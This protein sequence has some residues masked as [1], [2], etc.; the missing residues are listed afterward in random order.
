MTLSLPQRLVALVPV[1]TVVALLAQAVDDPGYAITLLGA[2]L[3]FAAIGPRADFD[4]PTQRIVL[5]M[6]GVAGAAVGLFIPPPLEGPALRGPWCALATAFAAMLAFRRVYA[7]PEGLG[8][9]DLALGVSALLAARQ[10][11]IAPW[12]FAATWVYLGAGFVQ[13]AVEDPGRARFTELPGR[14]RAFTVG[15]IGLAVL[16]SAGLALALPRFALWLSQRA[17]ASYLDDTANAGFEDRFDLGS[18]SI[19]GDSPT[20]AMRL[21][22][23]APSYLR[24]AVWNLYARGRWVRRRAIQPHRITPVHASPPDTAEV[25]WVERGAVSNESFFAPLNA[26]N[27][28]TTEGNARVD[29]FGVFRTIPGDPGRSWWFIEGPRPHAHVVAPVADD[30]TLTRR[31]PA[32]D[33]YLRAL[34]HTWTADHP[35]PTVRVARIAD[36][37]RREYRYA[38]TF[39]RTPQ[40]DPVFDFL[41]THREGHCEYFASA[42]TLLSRAADVPARVVGG[43]RVAEENTLSHE[44]IVRERNAHAW[45]EVYLEG[46]WRTLDATP[47][48]AVAHNRRHQTRGLRALVESWSTLLQ[49]G[50]EWLFSRSAG[51]LLFAA[52]VMLALWL[53]LR[54]RRKPSKT[55]SIQAIDGAPPMAALVALEALLAA[56]GHPR[57]P[58]E[59][60]SAWAARLDETRAL[61]PDQAQE[62]REAL[63]RFEAWRYGDLGDES[64]AREALSAVLNTLRRDAR[65][66]PPR[67]T[68]PRPDRRDP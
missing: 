50:K 57:A 7:R 9:V 4:L 47:E 66:D 12:F 48:G 6:A 55:K 44:W 2:S 51:E 52:G 61:S 30:L 15:T 45:V 65:P 24:G 16:L 31:D 43:Y 18:I 38:R 3:L 22:G 21:R 1:L 35:D 36:H 29:L 13:L 63:G 41:R 26:A 32:F 39:T 60:V 42:L 64:A 68:P 46:R 27:F 67:S 14:R 59:S 58:S 8:R 5:A 40:V 62:L 10:G 54:A 56:R 11:R 17:I 23:D 37:L 20:I 34:A 19:L 25:V 53:G 49:R 33:Q 28:G